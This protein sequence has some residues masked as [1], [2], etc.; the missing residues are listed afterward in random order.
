VWRWVVRVLIGLPILAVVA[1]LAF[2]VV[3][4]IRGRRAWT[5]C[6]KEL[7]A[8][9]ESLDPATFA[10]NAPLAESEDFF[11]AP[12]AQAWFRPGS[13]GGTKPLPGLPGSRFGGGQG[14]RSWEQ[15]VFTRLAEWQRI[16]EMEAAR[17]PGR[18]GAAGAVPRGP[19]TNAPSAQEMLKQ[20]APHTTNLTELARWLAER[21]RG[22]FS[23]DAGGLGAGAGV[24]FQNFSTVA[25]ALATRASAEL[26]LSNSA[27]A[28]EDV[29]LILRL[30]D[31]LRDEPFLLPAITRAGL[32]GQAI[33]PVWEGCAA[34]R[35][36]DSQLAGFQR[37]FG[38]CD[39]AGDVA[40]AMRRDRALTLESLERSPGRTFARASASQWGR[41]GDNEAQGFGILLSLA[42]RG[43]LDQNRASFCAAVQDRLAH[44]DAA[45]KE[46]PSRDEPLP[47][48]EQWWRRRPNP[49]TLLTMLTMQTTFR[50]GMVGLNTQNALGLVTVGCG[51][52][53]HRLAAGTLPETL[54]QLVPAYLDKLPE[55][56]QAVAFERGTE[57][58]F[59]LTSAERK[60]N[61]G[62]ERLPDDDARRNRPTWRYPKRR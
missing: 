7:A 35:W 55:G 46:P 9:G 50:A 29:L 43:W 25:S 40:T 18:R 33:Q 57:G 60:D 41:D 11:A 54:A 23:T 19:D 4:N 53:R 42:P 27:P 51:I 56:G 58:R 28:F 39:I 6:Q 17:A 8:H 5:G 14:Y 32:I 22:R 21:P 30:A 12:L 48:P 3:E 36:N 31:T 24:N 15:G 37:A 59:T 20:F 52:E 13:G 10:T 34:G 38:A 45:R 44:L 62:F 49:Y 1:V 2:Y 61:F 47:E 16:F 26:A